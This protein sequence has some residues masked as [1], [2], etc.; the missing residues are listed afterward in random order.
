MKE[1]KDFDCLEMKAEIQAKIYAEIKDMTTEERIAYYHVPPEKDI[2]R[3]RI[4]EN[5]FN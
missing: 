3:K 2:F 4:R 1:K 5:C